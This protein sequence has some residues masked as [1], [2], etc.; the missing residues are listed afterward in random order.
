MN[1]NKIQMAAPQ[2]TANSSLC[3]H[4]F[5]YNDFLRSCPAGVHRLYPVEL[6]AGLE[7]L[8]NAF[9]F[10]ELGGYKL[11]LLDCLPID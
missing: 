7:L 11:D 2:S 1:V 6:I 10:G 3:K 4:D 5:P 9:G 8:G